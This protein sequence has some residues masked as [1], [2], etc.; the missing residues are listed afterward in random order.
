MTALI[1]LQK[2]RIIFSIVIFFFSL[3]S[4]QSFGDDLDHNLFNSILGQWS[5]STGR[6]L[7]GVSLQWPPE[8]SPKK[9]VI[10]IEFRNDLT[11]RREI[12][13]MNSLSVVQEGSFS[14]NMSTLYTRITKACWDLESKQGICSETETPESK[15]EMI[16]MQGQQIWLLSTQGVRSG[17]C[18]ANDIII[19]RLTR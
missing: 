8:L 7:S 9:T 5:Y 13:K 1:S 14:I 17:L 6:C 2:K 10:R 15:A 4:F 3:L 12:F 18:P 19:L 16:T 11:W